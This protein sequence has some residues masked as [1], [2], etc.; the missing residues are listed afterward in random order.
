MKNSGLSLFWL[1]KNSLILDIK[2]W[3][4]SKWSVSKKTV[5][6]LKKY[7][8]LFLLQTGLRD[9][10]LGKNCIELF[11]KKIFYDCRFGLGDYQSIL[12]RHQ[13]MINI[14]DI[15]DTRV[16]IDV[17][18]NVG[19]F[20]MLIRDRF[21]NVIIYAV[22]PVRQIFQA[23]EANFKDD[24]KT[25]LANKAIS[26]FCGFVKIAFDAEDSACSHI[27]NKDVYFKKGEYH[28]LLPVDEADTNKS[29]R[30]RAQSETE[31][32]GLLPVG[33]YKEIL[34]IRLPKL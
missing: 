32:H 2:F 29:R 21:P 7:Y 33:I 15:K 18:A 30:R 31:N 23:L 17:G 6:L 22:E 14:A 24:S 12:T 19:F 26:N 9:F 16:V 13:N 5:F 1:I 20:S 11:G 25:I 3:Q 34:L 8:L 27:V 28:G 4:V 10:S